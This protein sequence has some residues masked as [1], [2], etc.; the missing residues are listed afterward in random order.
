MELLERLGLS[1]PPELLNRALTHAS[2]AH[3]LGEESN[4]RLEFLGDAVLD[5]AVADLLFHKFPTHEEG[6]LS[7]F[8]AVLV[9]RPV[10]AEIAQKLGLGEQ[11]RVAA[12]AEGSGARQRP[13]ILGAALEALVGAVFLHHGYAGARQLVEHLL[14]E[15]MKALQM[16]PPPDYK[17][18]LQELAQARY[19]ELPRYETVETE[20]AEHA[21]VFT[22]RVALGGEE[23]VG[24][25]RTKKEAEQAAAKRL[26]LKL[27]EAAEGDPPPNSD[28]QRDNGNR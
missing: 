19:H 27:A 16:Q 9:S 5:L 2:L 25:G 28:A 11:L 17:S 10:L 22:V 20:G 12:S 21:K 13:S 6:D 3:D 4:E 23:A 15:R 7:K 26:Y 24:R 14:A 1:L 8:R 18:L